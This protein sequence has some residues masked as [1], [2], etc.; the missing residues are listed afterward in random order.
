[1]ICISLLAACSAPKKYSYF[2]DRYS[3]QKERDHLITKVEPATVVA[4]S[5]SNAGPV[6]YASNETTPSEF[7]TTSFEE[8][9]SPLT[10]K[11]ELITPALKKSKYHF[12]RS[13]DK[14]DPTNEG[15]RE[16]FKNNSPFIGIG[17]VLAAFILFLINTGTVIPAAI[18]TIAYFGGLGF[19]ITGLFGKRRKLSLYS[20][21]AAV[22]IPVALLVAVIVALNNF[23]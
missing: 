10:T 19:L 7:A 6:L 23:Y 5:S 3:N 12:V 1:M 18:I 22:A 14:V 17:L 15:R 9:K 20:L 21:I 13:T 11:K 2:F 16:K 4:D 8:R